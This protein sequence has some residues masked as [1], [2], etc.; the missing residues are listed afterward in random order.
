MEKEKGLQRDIEVTKLVHSAF[1]DCDILVDGNNGF[2]I[3]EFLS[4]WK[5]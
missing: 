3:D 2:T 4:T 1:P 5:E